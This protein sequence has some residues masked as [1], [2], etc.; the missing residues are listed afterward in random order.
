MITSDPYGI[1]HATRILGDERRYVPEPVFTNDP[2]EMVLHCL[3]CTNM[4]CSHGECAYT[5]MGEGR[6]KHTRRTQAPVST[7]V[8]DKVARMWLDGWRK[9]MIARELNLTIYQVDRTLVWAEKEGLI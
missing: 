9:T 5:R 3:N 6:K 7:E 8:V 1:L 2:V 4:S